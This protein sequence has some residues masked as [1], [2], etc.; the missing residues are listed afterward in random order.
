M[1]SLENCANDGKEAGREVDN[2]MKSLHSK[3]ADAVDL[4]SL[5]EGVN[6]QTNLLA[7]NASIEAARAGEAD[8]GFAVVAD[9]IRS[10]AEQTASST[11]S[12]RHIFN[13]LTEQADVTAVNVEKMLDINEQ[14]LSLI[15]DTLLLFRRINEDVSDVSHSMEEQVEYSNRIS[16]SNNEMTNVVENLSSFSEELTANTDTTK[17]LNDQVIYGTETIANNIEG[18]VAEV[19]SLNQLIQQ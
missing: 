5:I 15:D 9:E 14:Q 19:E 8:K 11:D 17:E 18:L 12:I 1:H 4:I 2:S 6:K 16:D 7:L 3:I 13:S 10:L